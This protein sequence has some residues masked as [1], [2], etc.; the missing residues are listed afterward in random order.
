M[1]HRPDVHA[2]IIAQ[3]I[4]SELIVGAIGNVGIVDLAPFRR[5]QLVV[6]RLGGQAEEL[7]DLA[8]PLAVALGEIIVHRDQMGALSGQSVQIERH[9]GHQRFSFTGSHLGDFAFMQDDA[10]DQLHVVR[11]HIPFHLLTADHP[12]FA[13]QAATGLFHRR[14]R[15]RQKIIGGLSHAQ[16]VAELGSFGLEFIVGEIFIRFGQLIDLLHDGL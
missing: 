6:Q 10:A 11:H 1:H 7:V 2:H 15:F 5:I 4:E 3:I 12:F 13:Q 8:H 16:T 9:G 14:E